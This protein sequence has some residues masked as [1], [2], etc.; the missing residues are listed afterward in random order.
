MRGNYG[1]YFMIWV[2]RAIVADTEI[3]ICRQF[4]TNR[5]QKRGFFV[6][7]ISS[8]LGGDTIGNR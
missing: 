5:V 6:V 1:M 2:Q 7:N 8:E 4:N 3:I